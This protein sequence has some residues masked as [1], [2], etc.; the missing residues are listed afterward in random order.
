MTSGTHRYATYAFTMLGA[1]CD[2]SGFDSSRMVRPATIVREEL[3]MAVKTGDQLEKRR[4][5]GD[6]YL[7]SFARYFF[8]GCKKENASVPL[9]ATQTHHMTSQADKQTAGISAAR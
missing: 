8:V 3:M 2:R 9:Q 1:N 6:F 4:M 7:F 5:R